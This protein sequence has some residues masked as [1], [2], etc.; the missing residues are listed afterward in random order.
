[1]LS[2]KTAFTPDDIN[3]VLATLQLN[4]LLAKGTKTESFQKELFFTFLFNKSTNGFVTTLNARGANL[5]NGT[6]RTIM[7][8]NV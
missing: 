2:Y 5:K 1:M 3:T 4:L 7:K 6:P 8:S